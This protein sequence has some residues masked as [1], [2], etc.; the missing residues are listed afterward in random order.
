[1]FCS[2]PFNTLHVQPNAFIT[3]CPSW[4]KDSKEVIVRGH[5]DDLWKMWNHENFVKLRQSWLNSDN[6]FCGPCI[7]ALNPNAFND[8]LENCMTPIMTRGPKNIQFANDLSCNLHCWSCRSKPIIEKQQEKIFNQTKSVLDTFYDSIEFISAIGSG[9]PFAS[10]AWLKILQT[11]DMEKHRNLKIELFTN[12]LLLPRYWDSI[13]HMHEN[14]I[15]I[16]MSIDAV[17]KDIYEKTRLGGKHENLN[18]AL[19]FISK[20]GKQFILNMVV[21]SENFTDIPKLCERAIQL[22]CHKVNLTMI[23]Y[24]P[25]MRGGKEQFDKVNLA[26]PQ[27][28]KRKEFLNLLEDSYVQELLS[29]KIIDCNRILPEGHKIIKF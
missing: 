28:P 23:R 16:K 14:I 2:N 9:D 6:K 19:E 26:N 1:M 11:M 22:G 5:F 18:E 4:F 15:R 17:S 29:H 21:E 27:H 20:L 13:S 24:W 8:K 25:S 12:G 7:L 10:P 3:C